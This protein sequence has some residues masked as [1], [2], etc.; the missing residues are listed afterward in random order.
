[1]SGPNNLT[2]T[3]AANITFGDHRGTGTTI[4]QGATS[5]SSSGLRLDGG[6]VLR[7]EG[8]LTW[9]G[10]QILF[11]NTF[12]GAS[13]GPGS[14]TINNVAGATF[15]ASGDNAT[16]I[17]ASNFGGAD[18]GAA[19]PANARRP[20]ANRALIRRLLPLPLRSCRF[21]PPCQIIRE[22]R[23]G[24]FQR[25]AALAGRLAFRGQTL[26]DRPDG[27]RA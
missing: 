26:C 6:R 10:G 25:L 17:V 13:G 1:M 21:Y 8:A 7:N 19:M 24:V 9:S 14:G 16:S 22:P 20:E 11:N 18:T 27:D 2:V 12:N 5:I 15:V 23:K 4:L 3:G